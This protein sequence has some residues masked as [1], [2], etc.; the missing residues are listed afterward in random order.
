MNSHW[1]FCGRS[2]EMTET[3]ITSSKEEYWKLR[4]D[5]KKVI[6][7][8]NFIGR[9]GIIEFERKTRTINRTGSR[10]LGLSYYSY[11]KNHITASFV[12]SYA[13]VKLL[14]M[15]KRIPYERILYVDTE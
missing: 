5:K 2:M 15:M 4:N 1:G 9:Y 3:V 8:A 14:Q 10:A 11:K 6:K 12:T 7:S 13:R